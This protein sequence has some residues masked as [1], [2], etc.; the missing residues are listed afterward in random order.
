MQYVA[1]HVTCLEMMIHRD[2]FSAVIYPY[3]FFRHRS[4]SS[5]CL[6]VRSYEDDD[7]CT[8]W[9]FY[10]TCLRMVTHMDQLSVIFQFRLFKISVWI[11]TTMCAVYGLFDITEV[12]LKAVRNAIRQTH[13]LTLS[14][15]RTIYTF[16]TW[17]LV[18]WKIHIGQRIVLFR[19]KLMIL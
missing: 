3:I 11:R 18:E 10:V 12:L 1:L 19:D 6:S 2:H 8:V 7:V 4:V 16:R 15:I 17:K 5:V 14:F 13:L 9:M